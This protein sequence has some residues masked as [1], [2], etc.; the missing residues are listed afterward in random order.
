MSGNIPKDI[1]SQPATKL[2]NLALHTNQFEGELPSTLTRCHSLK[3]LSMARNK[4]TG[5]I[6]A[7]FWNLSAIQ[8]F[9]LARNQFT[10]I[11]PPLIGNL[12][13]LEIFDISENTFYGM[14]PP[15]IGQLSTFKLLNL[16]VSGS[17]PFSMDKGLQDIEALYFTAINSMERFLNLSQISPGSLYFSFLLTQFTGVIPTTLGNLAQLQIFNVEDNQLT[18]NMVKPEQDFLSS[19]TACK[20]VKAIR[21]SFNPITG[22]LPKSL[23]SK[24]LSASLEEFLADSCRIISPLPDEIGNLSNLMKL[25][26]GDNGLHGAI[27]TTLWHLTNLQMLQI[28]GNKLQGIVQFEEFVLHKFSPK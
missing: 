6:P 28:Q 26:L 4:F 23:G 14:I 3:F 24:N 12:S 8:A 19:L 16:G 27:P 1:C 13:N 18:N 9:D 5:K 22:V 7:D 11:I 10:G 17:L 21:I 2:E 25:R 20:H 15:E